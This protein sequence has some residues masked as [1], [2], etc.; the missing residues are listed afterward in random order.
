MK[1]IIAT[2]AVIFSLATSATFAYDGA[3]VNKSV[4]KSFNREFSGAVNATWQYVGSGI[5]RVSFD[6]GGKNVLAFFD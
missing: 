4:L 3:G 5:L 2:L 1:K 6:Y